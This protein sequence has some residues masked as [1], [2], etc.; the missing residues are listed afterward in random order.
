MK[1][2]VVICNNKSEWRLFHDTLTFSLAKQGYKYKSVSEA[3]HDLHDNIRYLYFPNNLYKV[4]EKLY[5]YA[6]GG[7]TVFN[8]DRIVGMCNIEPDVLD[9]LSVYLREQEGENK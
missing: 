2:V 5:C 4:S 8:I 3:I 6:D 9:Y 7:D 1:K